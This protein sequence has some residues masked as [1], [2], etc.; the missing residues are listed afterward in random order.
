MKELLNSRKFKKNL[1]KWL[2]M[3]CG[4]M[5][6]FTIVITYSKYLS[7]R[8]FK[9]SARVAKF[10]VKI[11]PTACKDITPNDVACGTGSLRPDPRVGFYFK[12]DTSKIEVKTYVN[13]SI[14]IK[15]A[16]K[17]STTGE[18]YF[19]NYKLYKINNNTF[20][21]GTSLTGTQV[22]DS[23]NND[24]D[25]TKLTLEETIESGKGKDQEYM[26][27]MDNGYEDVLNGDKLI[28]VDYSAVQLVK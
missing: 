18:R 24:T 26:L 1:L 15:N 4:V 11:E 5:C 19:S 13:I 25:T 2:F 14:N 28:T 9:D 17:N 20:D 10:D 6:I 23:E 8:S 12:I 7:T 3:Y 16:I 27:V 21:E 22:K